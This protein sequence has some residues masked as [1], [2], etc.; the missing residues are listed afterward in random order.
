ALVARILR[1]GDGATRHP[2]CLGEVVTGV[3]AT[4]APLRN[5][6]RQEQTA[7]IAGLPCRL[8]AGETTSNFAAIFPVLW[9]F[10]EPRCR[11][12]GAISIPADGTRRRR[13]GR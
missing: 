4:A 13:G 6:N 10:H 3:D 9:L 7:R 11:P 12:K 8:G 2:H 5:L 1:H